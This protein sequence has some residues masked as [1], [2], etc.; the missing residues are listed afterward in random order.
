MRDRK[1]NTIIFPKEW[2]SIV[3]LLFFIL[4]GLLQAQVKNSVYSMFG[5]GQITDKSYGV[6]NALGGTGIAFRSGRSINYLNPASYLGIPAN[7]FSTEI[8]AYG[9]YN[10]SANENTSQSESSINVSYF[11]ANLYLKNWWAF[12]FGF[13]P[14]SSVNYEI[15]SSGEIGSDLTT[16]DK[17]F[18]GS[19]GLNRINYGN[20]FRIYKG[21]SAGFNTSYI[22]GHITHTETAVSID[23]F[24]GYELK[25]DQTVH[26]YYFDYGLLY[27]IQKKEWWY[28]LGLVYGP[29]KNLSSTSNLEFTYNDETDDLEQD[30]SNSLIIPQ[31]FGFGLSVEKTDNFR[32]GFDYEWKNWS[33][34]NTSTPSVNIK[35]S[36]RFSVG[37]EY[38]P[39]QED[40]RLSSICYRLGANYKNSYLKIKSTPI[41]SAGITFGL[42]IPFGNSNIINLSFEY[43]QEGTLSK[44][45]IKNNYGIFYL[46]FSLHEFWARRF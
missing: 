46:S 33:G 5:V 28:R 1:Q 27:S 18:E 8:G 45:L 43:G 20:S 32:A 11:S 42:G 15:N 21:L 23:N 10:R 29:R 9:I 35:N 17:N 4:P 26:S 14:L 7:S 31:K 44:N 3:T 38:S 13:F 12:S 25:N 6:N 24:T 2:V 19:G 40:K 16:Y 41:N 36:H 22:F 34:I 37:L 30:E 39:L